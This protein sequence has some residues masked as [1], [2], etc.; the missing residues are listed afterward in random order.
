MNSHRLRAVLLA[1]DEGAR[2][3]PRLSIRETVQAEIE[4][5]LEAVPSG[6]WINTA[7]GTAWLC[8]ALRR[9]EGPVW[10]RL[11]NVMPR[12]SVGV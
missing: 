2:G 5:Y 12:G 3:P 11:R 6:G 8:E 9:S 10:M 1:V 4:G 7:K